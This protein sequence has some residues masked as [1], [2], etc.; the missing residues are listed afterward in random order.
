MSE[1]QTRGKWTGFFKEKNEDKNVSLAYARLKQQFFL[2]F[3]SIF[4]L[5]YFNLPLMQKKLQYND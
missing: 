1:R 4:L 3:F 5:F 2:F